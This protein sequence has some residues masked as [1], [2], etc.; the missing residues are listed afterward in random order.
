MKGGR[1]GCRKQRDRKEEWNL[2][3][4]VNGRREGGLQEQRDRK[5][6]W[7]LQNRVKGRR[8]ETAAGTEG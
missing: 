8:E 1:D 7:T 5:E 4:R 2:Q 6:E 3:N